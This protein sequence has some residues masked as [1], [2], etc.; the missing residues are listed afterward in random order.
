ML[1]SEREQGNMEIPD[2]YSCICFFSGLFFDIKHHIDHLVGFGNRK[3][4]KHSFEHYVAIECT[5]MPLIIA[6]ERRRLGLL[7]TQMS[8]GLLSGNLKEKKDQ[9]KSI[10]CLT[11]NLVN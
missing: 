2:F 7:M 9:F 4:V 10:K 5:Q 6:T 8:R 1:K 11:L 3:G